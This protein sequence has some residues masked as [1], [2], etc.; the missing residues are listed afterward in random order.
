[1]SERRESEQAREIGEIRPHETTHIHL[2]IKYYSS[3]TSTVNYGVSRFSSPFPTLCLSR[4]ARISFPGRQFTT[5]FLFLFAGFAL[6]FRALP[7]IRFGS[8]QPLLSLYAEPLFLKNI[9][10][11]FFRFMYFQ[12]FC[13]QRFH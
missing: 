7:F 4:F 9:F 12:V 2:S 1:M 3:L 5:L 11:V 10:L 6:A 8:L 13:S